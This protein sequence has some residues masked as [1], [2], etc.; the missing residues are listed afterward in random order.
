MA[1]QMKL[2]ESHAEDCI[3][4]AEQTDDVAFRKMLLLLALQWK[5]AARS[6]QEQ[7]RTRP[8]GVNTA[9]NCVCTTIPACTAN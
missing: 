4:A 2:Y 3:R 6:K 9:F 5:L 1:S 8:H 7:A